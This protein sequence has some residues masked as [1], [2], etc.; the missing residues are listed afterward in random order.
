[1]RDEGAAQVGKLIVPRILGQAAFQANVIAMTTI[2]SFLAAGSLAAFNSGYV[3]MMLPHG[4]FAM[5]L[6]TV[7]F[8]TMSALFGQGKLDDLRVTLA[9]AVKVLIFL[10][11]PASVGMFAL[12]DELVATLFQLQNFDALDTSRVS[13][14]LTYFALGLVAYAVV[15]IV[16]RAFYALQDTRTPVLVAVLTVVLNIGLATFLALGLNMNQDGLALSWLSPLRP[17]W[18]CCGCSWAA[19]CPIGDC[20]PTASSCRL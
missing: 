7:T 1:L 9:R 16:T 17:R 13:S 8:P 3:I 20:R 14:T 5:S 15:E 19:S 2:T 4:V 10:T 18:C 12:R 11:I 6:A